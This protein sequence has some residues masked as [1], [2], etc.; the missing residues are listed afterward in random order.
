MRSSHS[1]LSTRFAVP[2]VNTDADVGCLLVKVFNELTQFSN[3]VQALF[4]PTYMLA[5][6]LAPRA[7][8][9]FMTTLSGLT[10]EALT[11]ALADLD[12]GKIPA[13]SA[14]MAAS[15]SEASTSEARAAGYKG[16][17]APVLAYWGLPEGVSMRAVL[18]AMRADVAARMVVNQG[19]DFKTLSLVRAHKIYKRFIHRD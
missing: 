3:G 5:F 17:P 19:A 7:C 13:W 10:G 12:A 15:A 1:Q 4:A 16:L 6:T 18:L 2:L 8:H 9:A 14:P 11:D